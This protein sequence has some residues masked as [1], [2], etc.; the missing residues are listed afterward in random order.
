MVNLETLHSHSDWS[1]LGDHSVELLASGQYAAIIEQ[2]L[3]ADLSV[4]FGDFDGLLDDA[5]NSFDAYCVEINF[6]L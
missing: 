2:G 4:D 5:L 1:G 3:A 6:E